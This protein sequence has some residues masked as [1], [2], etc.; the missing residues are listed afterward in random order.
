MYVRMYNFHPSGEINKEKSQSYKSRQKW[1][2]QQQQQKLQSIE[3]AM[4]FESR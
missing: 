3:K 1:E 2:L 4:L